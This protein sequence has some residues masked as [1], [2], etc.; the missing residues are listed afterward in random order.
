[1]QR[2]LPREGD[3]PPGPG[4]PGN[5]GIFRSAAERTHWTQAAPV[6]Q[7]WPWACQQMRGVFAFTPATEEDRSAEGMSK[8][9]RVSP[10]CPSFLHLRIRPFIQSAL[11]VGASARL[12]PECHW[13][14]PKSEWILGLGGGP[15][16][17]RKELLPVTKLVLLDHFPV[18][19]FLI[20]PHH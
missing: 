14:S 13:E 11:A 10:N 9:P 7:R 6:A 1:M 16:L 3:I 4:Q 19:D 20:S 18:R 8:G 12:Q 15:F 17:R 2:Q 5:P